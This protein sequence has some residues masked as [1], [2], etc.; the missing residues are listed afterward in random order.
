MFIYPLENKLF[1]VKKIV[2]NQNVNDTDCGGKKTGK[3]HS[4]E[5]S[6]PPRMNSSLMN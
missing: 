1:A 3:Y 2:R 4:T 6:L 5:K